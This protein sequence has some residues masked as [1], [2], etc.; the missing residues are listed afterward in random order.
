MTKKLVMKSVIFL[1]MF[2]IILYIINFLKVATNTSLNKNTGV[3]VCS[4]CVNTIM[5]IESTPTLR[6]LAIN[7]LG[8][9]LSNK[10]SNS[11]F[12]YYY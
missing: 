10:D 12:N 3:S 11:K 5:S 7:V 4:E 9:F 6:I 8:K 1:L 2:K